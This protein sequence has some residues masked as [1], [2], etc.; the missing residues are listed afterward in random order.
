MLSSDDDDDEMSESCVE[1]LRW[2][3]NVRI[4]IKSRRSVIERWIPEVTSKNKYQKIIFCIF[5]LFKNYFLCLNVCVRFLHKSE[6]SE[7]MC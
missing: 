3:C 5:D 2:S 6:S 7:S 4:L 1:L